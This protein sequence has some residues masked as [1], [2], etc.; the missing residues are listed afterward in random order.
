MIVSPSVQTFSLSRSHSGATPPRGAPRH[1][2][3]AC[4]AHPI[5]SAP[6][7]LNASRTVMS[8]RGTGCTCVAFSSASIFVAGAD[9]RLQQQ[10]RARSPAG[11]PSLCARRRSISGVLPPRTTFSRHGPATTL[12]HRGEFLHRLRR[13]D[14]RHVGAGRQRRIGAR[15]RL[16]EAGDRARIG[17]RDDHE[18]ADLRWRRPRRGSSRCNPRAARSPCRRDG[19]I[20]S[21]TPGPRYGSPAT[22]RR[23]YSARCGTR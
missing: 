12:R 1:R 2:G 6:T 20:S 11:S 10:A 8:L 14:E 15:H 22:P 5:P 9:H 16:V 17:A 19:R 4:A 23:S 13:L 18:V 3:S 21:A 7:R